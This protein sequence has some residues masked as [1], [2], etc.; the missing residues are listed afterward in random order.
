MEGRAPLGS[1][2]KEPRARKAAT[3]ADGRKLSNG[4][5]LSKGGRQ[6]FQ[7]G[8]REAGPTRKAEEL[9]EPLESNPR[10]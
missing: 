1:A 5:G 3:S 9:Q 7:G 2:A 6:P 4:K 10:P 8:G